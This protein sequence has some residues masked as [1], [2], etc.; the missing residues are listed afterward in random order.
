[1]I[2]QGFFYENHN[3]VSVIPPIDFDTDR[4]GT[5]IPVKPA[6]LIT[7]IV[8][9]A[10]GTAGDDLTLSVKQATDSS[11]TGAK[12]LNVVNTAF[13]LAASTAM[14]KLALSP[15][16][17]TIDLAGVVTASGTTDTALDSTA[18][19]YFITVDPAS[20]DTANSFNHVTIFSEGDALS[21]AGLAAVLAVYQPRN[22]VNFVAA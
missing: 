21:N 2:Q 1:M 9:K 18:G 4:T 16:T 5:Y 14:T 10:A 19:F 3:V 13:K 15:T 7:F 11:G 22:G 17:D 6:H 8:Y 20:L 12:A